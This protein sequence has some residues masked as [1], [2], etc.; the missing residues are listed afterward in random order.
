MVKNIISPLK[1]K[2][3]RGWD[4]CCYKIYH[5]WRNNIILKKLIENSKILI[6][7]SGPSANDFDNIPDDVKIFTCNYG[8]KLLSDKNIKRGIDLFI[9]FRFCMETIEHIEKTISEHFHKKI[10]FFM[11]DDLQYIKGKE[12]LNKSY[13]TLMKYNPRENH[14]LLRLI[15]PYKM[16]DIHGTSKPWNSTGLILLQFAI[17]FQAKIIYLIGIDLGKEHFYTQKYRDTD[18]SEFSY[19]H[20]DIDSAFID[21]VSKRYHHI[22]SVS[23][24]SAITRYIPY[25]SL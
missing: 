16:R 1:T 7:G 23:K 11:T 15:S 24:N 2:V 5:R 22:Y 4:A 12:R 13:G 19:Q 25:K 9:G 6:L 10:N 20:E 17:Y 14:Y 21:I 8:P 3:V 18:G